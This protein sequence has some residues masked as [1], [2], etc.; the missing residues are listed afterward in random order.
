[1][2]IRQICWAIFRDKFL[3]LLVINMDLK[4]HSNSVR[5]L[6]MKYWVVFVAN[7]FI[8]RVYYARS[9]PI[10]MNMTL[11]YASI[12]KKQCNDI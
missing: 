3:K 10:G 8:V 4:L 9:W 6:N 2:I 12:H 7:L 5:F 1:M 11:S